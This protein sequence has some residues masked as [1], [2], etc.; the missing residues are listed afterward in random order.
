MLAVAALAGCTQ[1]FIDRLDRGAERK[2]LNATMT[3]DGIHLTVPGCPD[4]T[5]PTRTN[6]SNSV[7]SNFGCADATNFGLMVADPADV[8]AGRNPGPADG[9]Y[10]AGAIERYRKGETKPQLSG[11]WATG[12]TESGGAG[13][14]GGAEK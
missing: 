12:A 6:Y 10:A 9:T 2:S 14:S 4:W 5:K 1:N 7:H 3:P 13:E 11:T 8:W